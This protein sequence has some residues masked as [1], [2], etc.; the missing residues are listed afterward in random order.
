ME[1]NACKKT[2]REIPKIFWWRLFEF[3]N[4][5]LVG[6]CGLVQVED[7]KCHEV[8]PTSTEMCRPEKPPGVVRSKKCTLGLPERYMEAVWSQ[9]DRD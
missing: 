2:R 5:C 1:L 8:K 7:D 4:F 6:N 3:F 9:L